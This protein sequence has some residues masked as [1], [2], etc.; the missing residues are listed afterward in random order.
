MI[1]IIVQKYHKILQI[2]GRT[3]YFAAAMTK[4][5]QFEFS[6]FA[7]NTYVVYDDTG[8]C[9]IIDPGCY[10]NLE[11]QALT[12]FI[13]DQELHPV[14]LIN[15]HCHI[16]HVFGNRFV[17]EKYSL[18]LEVHRF[19][20]PVLAWLPQ[21]ALMFGV[22]AEPSPH[23]GHFIEEG[24]TIVFGT[25]ALEVLFTPGHSPGSLS[26]Y[27]RKAG[28]IL[29][30]D[31]LFFGSIGR[32]DLPGGDYDTLLRSIREKLLPLD[33]DTRVFSGHGQMTTIG[34]ERRYNPFLQ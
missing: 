3:L 18:Q 16:D 4:V 23:P 17:A 31:V 20:L 14:K 34:F 7:E 10:D 19:E 24:D 33:D 30:G 9:I 13:A 26:F 8:E 27:C 1:T 5:K 25:T 2:S 11:R 15:T 22:A 32:T 12:D 28:F 21:S 6:P 29:S